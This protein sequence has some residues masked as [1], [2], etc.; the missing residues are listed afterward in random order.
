[1]ITV[2]Q[3]TEFKGVIQTATI[4]G[5]T[6]DN[7]DVSITEAY[8]DGEWVTF[9]TPKVVNVLLTN[10]NTANLTE[11]ELAVVKATIIKYNSTLTGDDKIIADSILKKLV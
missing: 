3:K 11:Q 7:F 9:A 5:E 2:G 10:Y 1:M 4:A 6:T 8:I